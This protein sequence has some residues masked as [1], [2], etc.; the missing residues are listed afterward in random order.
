MDAVSTAIV[1]AVVAGLMLLGIGMVVNQLLRLRRY[2]REAP[3]DQIP[4]ENP[5]P[6]RQ[7]D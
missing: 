4:G 5:E 3:P 7:P 2:L 6:P 1:V